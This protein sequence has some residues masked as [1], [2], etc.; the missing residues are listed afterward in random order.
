ML[1]DLFLYRDGILPDLPQCSVAFNN[2]LKVRRMY[3]R[4]YLYANCPNILQRKGCWCGS[5]YL[6]TCAVH[7]DVSEPA[8]MHAHLKH[9][10]PFCPT[11]SPPSPL[12]PIIAPPPVNCC[13]IL[14]SP[15]QQKRARW[16]APCTVSATLSNQPPLTM[17]PKTPCTVCIVLHTCTRWHMQT[18]VDELYENV[19]KKKTVKIQYSGV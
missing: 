10:V 9:E 3:V 4:T 7:T 14:S 12:I 13:P 18:E 15:L 17:L 16:V 2:L 1:A 19:K 11:C 6:P 8:C 5:G